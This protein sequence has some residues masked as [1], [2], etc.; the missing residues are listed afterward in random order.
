MLSRNELQAIMNDLGS[1]AKERAVAQLRLDA[2]PEEQKPPKFSPEAG[3]MLRE[4]GRSHLC[5][6]S[7]SEW[8]RYTAQH[9]I[10]GCEALCVEYWQWN[11]PD[12]DF[13]EL[14]SGKEGSEA[15]VEHWKSVRRASSDPHVQ[16]HAASQ[17]KLLQKQP[18]ERDK[19]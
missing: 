5:D 19:Q 7:E 4:F 8:S 16:A 15:Q 9:G 2:M 11:L 1:T 3:E 12:Q 17:I 18:I 10:T 6:V 14:I 13:L